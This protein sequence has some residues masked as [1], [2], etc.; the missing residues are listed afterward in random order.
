MK[1]NTAKMLSLNTSQS[2]TSISLSRN[3][4]A[5]V[6]DHW[7]ASDAHGSFREEGY[8]GIQNLKGVGGGGERGAGENFL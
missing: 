8:L 5:Y 7:Y 2:N 1:S 4:C 3:I 6:L